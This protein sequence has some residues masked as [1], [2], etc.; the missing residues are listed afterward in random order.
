[1]FVN[2]VIWR[3]RIF[4]VELGDF[5]SK[6]DLRRCLCGTSKFVENENISH[7]PLSA[8]IYIFDGGRGLCKTTSSI[9]C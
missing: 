2:P 3:K 5:G 8:R 7:K 6:T 4:E 9:F 1:M